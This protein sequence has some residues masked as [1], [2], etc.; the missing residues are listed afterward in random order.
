MT[1]VGQQHGRVLWEGLYR[2]PK[3]EP[4][5]VA[6]RVVPGP[7]AE[8]E[9][10]VTP[11]AP[12]VRG[13]ADPMPGAFTPRA[14]TDRRALASPVSRFRPPV[15]TPADREP[16]TET[17]DATVRTPAAVRVTDF[18]RDRAVQSGTRP[19]RGQ[20]SVSLSLETGRAVQ[21]LLNAN[22]AALEV[23]GALGP[24]F[25]RALADFRKANGLGDGSG[26]G[27]GLDRGTM[28]ALMEGARTRPATRD[29]RFVGFESA[30]AEQRVAGNMLALLSSQD[31]KRFD[32]LMRR[33]G[34]RAPANHDITPA[35]ADQ[36]IA[37]IQRPTRGHGIP[38][39][40]HTNARLSFDSVPLPD[41]EWN[42]EAARVAA[43]LGTGR[44]APS[45]S[46][47]Q[48]LT[49]GL[50]RAVFNDPMLRRAAAEVGIP[51]HHYQALV[52]VESDG[53]WLGANGSGAVGY[54]QV[55]PG[56]AQGWRIRDGRMVFVGWNGGRGQAVDVHNR[57]HNLRLGAHNLA[58]LYDRAARAMSLP[59]GGPRTDDRVWSTV[60][61]GY[62]S[63]MG[64]LDQYV[65]TPDFPETRNHVDQIRAYV[66]IFGARAGFTPPGSS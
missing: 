59:T 47:P 42:Y 25:R 23:D 3:A 29:R 61:A 58:W 45:A 39:N 62:N 15:D 9:P 28:D 21:R 65:G 66:A 35:I 22:G 26:Y 55:T 16:S 56:L 53:E 32:A 31:P 48:R 30:T 49:R 1:G 8:V 27:T 13:N 17:T 36:V 57:S 14:E 5:P 12:L 41:G 63:G 46:E 40:A 11:L 34:V 51:L 6:P 33:I 44:A 50:N 64:R 18:D 4:Q 37:V 24:R 54:S 20:G 19:G 60:H 52:A 10:K 7:P 2:T 38:I 43:D